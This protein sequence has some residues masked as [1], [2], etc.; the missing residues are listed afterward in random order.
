ML[1]SE[2]NCLR[3]GEFWMKPNDLQFLNQN[4]LN[5]TKITGKILKWNMDMPLLLVY[6]EYI[7]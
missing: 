3:H 4:E 6:L 7:K 1:F 2:K 5:E